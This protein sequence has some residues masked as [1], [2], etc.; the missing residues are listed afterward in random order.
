[1]LCAFP[2]RSEE[3]RKSRGYGNRTADDI[4]A[5][6]FDTLEHREVRKTPN[7]KDALER[8]LRGREEEGRDFPRANSKKLFFSPHHAEYTSFHIEGR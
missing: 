4:S 8:K 6:E 3:K 2:K 5:Q 1:M 7:T